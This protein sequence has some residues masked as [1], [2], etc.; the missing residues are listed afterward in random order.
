MQGKF[1]I[2][3]IED[4]YAFCVMCVKRSG[5]KVRP[6]EYEDIVAEA[7]CHL[8]RLSLKF[9]PQMEGYDQQGRFSGYAVKFLPR[10]I[11]REWH[12]SKENHLYR[13][14]SDGT[15]RWEVLSEATTLESYVEGNVRLPGEFINVP[16]E[17]DGASIGVHEA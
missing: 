4:A 13:T 11:A 10:I 5:A 15:R 16:Q 6:H 14:Q 9:E 8:W 17:N 1:A 2:Y 3:D 12:R 7:L